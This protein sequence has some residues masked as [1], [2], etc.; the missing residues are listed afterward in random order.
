ME[1]HPSHRP[2]RTDP[3]DP[4]NPTTE[5][6]LCGVE[7]DRVE[8]GEPCPYKG[9]GSVGYVEPPDPERARWVAM[10]RHLSDHLKANTDVLPRVFFP[11]AEAGE[12]QPVPL[13]GL[14]RTELVADLLHYVA[15]M[16]EE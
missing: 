12:S 6:D 4:E 13:V 2:V 10:L 9:P 16:V 7:G 11:E 1:Y 15:D 5:C 8:V 14:V 3:Y